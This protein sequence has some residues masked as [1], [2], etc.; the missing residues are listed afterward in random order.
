MFAHFPAILLD[1]HVESHL[2]PALRQALCPGLHIII[3]IIITY[4]VNDY[5]EVYKH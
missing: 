1:V 5:M 3:I 4:R 2:R